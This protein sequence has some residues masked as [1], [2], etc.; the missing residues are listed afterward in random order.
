MSELRTTAIKTTEIKSVKHLMAVLM[1]KPEE[2]QEI[3]SNKD[4]YYYKSTKPKI[5][6]KGNPRLDVNGEIEYR[7][8]YPSKGR[9]KQIQSTIK[10]RILSKIRNNFLIAF[11]RRQAQAYGRIQLER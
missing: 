3:I 10:N 9:L 4:S 6:K 2:L 11:E 5:D 8:L 7:T 1:C